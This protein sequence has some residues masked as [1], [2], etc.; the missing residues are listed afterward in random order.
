[1]VGFLADGDDMD[2]SFWKPFG[3]KRVEHILLTD[4]IEQIRRRRIEWAVVGD[5]YLKANGVSLSAWL[6]QT[7]AEVKGTASGILKVTEGPQPWY[8]VKFKGP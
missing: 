7:G 4:S 5:A 6:D 8:V 2:I 3:Q 1:V